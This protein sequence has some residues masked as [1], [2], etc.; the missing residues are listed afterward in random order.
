MDRICASTDLL[1]WAEKN[2]RELVPAAQTRLFVSSLQVLRELPLSR[3][4]TEE[5]AIVKNNL[6]RYRKAVYKNKAAKKSVRIMAFG[7]AMDIRLLKK[8]GHLYKLICR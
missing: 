4:Y 1:D 2:C 5:I 7:A 8:T 6:R 3:E